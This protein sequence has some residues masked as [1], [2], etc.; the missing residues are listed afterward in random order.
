M[1][2]NV[3]VVS[4]IPAKY[5]CDNLNVQRYPHLENIPISPVKSGDVVD[6]LIGMD[7]SH[8]LVPLDVRFNPSSLREPHATKH[9]FGW[10]LNGIDGDCGT[11]NIFSHFVGLDDKIENMWDLEYQHCDSKGFSVEDN[12]VLTLWQNEIER[13]DGHYVLPIPWQP[14]KPEFPNNKFLAQCRLDSLDKRLNKLDLVKVYDVKM[15]SMIDKDYAE[16]VSVDE[17]FLDDGSVWYIPHHPVLSKPGKVR[18]VFDCAAPFKGVCLNSEVKQGPN[19]INDLVS[20]LLRFRQY[21]YAVTADIEDMYLQVRVP[22]SQRNALRFL[23]YD[24]IND[25]GNPV[26]YRMKTHLFGGKWCAS[27]TAFALK[28]TVIDCDPTPLV[29][30]TI[31]R[32]FYVDDLLKSLPNVDD[33]VDLISD[34]QPV[35]QYGGFKLRKFMANDS[36]IL[37]NVNPVDQANGIKSIIPGDLTKALGILWDVNNDTFQYTSRSPPTSSSVTRRSMLSF[38]SSLYDPVGWISPVVLQGKLFQESTRLKLD[39]DDCIPQ[40]LERQWDSWTQSLG[41]INAIRIDRCVIPP[42]FE[43][44]VFQLHHFCDASH[45]SYGAC[46]YL[47]VIN[48]RGEIHVTLLA[49]KGR[50]APIKTLTVPRLELCAAV[51]AVKLDNMLNTELGVKLIPSVFWSDSQITLAYISNNKKRFKVF[52]ANRV[53]KIRGVSVPEQWHYIESGLN[54][55]DVLSR[56]CQVNQI[57]EE[58]FSGPRFLSDYK[59]HWQCEN[60]VSQDILCQD[61][62]VCKP[63][64]IDSY[65]T[66]H[67]T[68]DVYEHPIES[69]TNHYSSYYKLQ[70]AVSWLLRF[71]MYLSSK[72]LVKGPVT[73]KELIVAENLV[74][75]HAQVQS[76]PEEVKMLH[77]SGKIKVS[78]PLAPLSPRLEGNLMVVGGRLSQAPISNTSKSQIILPHKSRISYL[79]A[80]DMHNN[81]HL[82]IE[83]TLCCLRKKY[84]VVRARPLIKK[85]KRSCVTC[86]KALFKGTYTENGNVAT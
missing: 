45:A 84:W 64:V 69:L 29:A 58:W 27:S 36:E 56:G 52:V 37:K 44:G 16:R 4:N 50:L 25:S 11:R 76:Y 8:L 54:P 18:P 14:G 48:Q 20:V 3:L 28:Q 53:A 62:E 57:P 12:E 30:D 15:Q 63:K 74:L 1:L 79:I 13:E 51:E 72:I 61:A 31:E 86:K 26:V 22:Q 34:I 77:Q 42:G 33:A 24:P 75:Q 7:N 2:N 21:R 78:S 80:L 47:R 60:V 6:V 41:D 39:W 70:K 40:H 46:S 66:E 23:W 5:P 32:S 17:L 83:W 68:N 43:N 9:V 35:L 38:V 67:V 71:K 82:G 49:S 10:V 19:L 81:A 55:S 65:A 59:C 85:I 73:V